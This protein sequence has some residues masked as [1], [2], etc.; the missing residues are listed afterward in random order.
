MI[1]ELRKQ[2]ILDRLARQEV[3][4]L[5]ELARQ[6]GISESTVRRDLKALEQEGQ[7]QLLRGGG[8]RLRRETAELR[9]ETK[10]GLNRVGKE[11]IARAAAALI[12]PG[13]V[14]FIDPSSTNHL[15]IDLVRAEG[16]M[17]ISNSVLHIT[18]LL[19]QGKPCMLIGGQI[20]AGTRSTYGPLA[21][22]GM[23]GLRFTKAFLGANG[24][25]EEAGITNHDP[26]ERTVKRLAIELASRSYFLIDRSKY[27]AVTLCKVAELTE[28]Q[29][30][31]DEVPPAL[32]GYANIHAAPPAESHGQKELD[33]M[34]RI[35]KGMAVRDETI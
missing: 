27:G 29:I 26:Q 17:F 12:E 35:Q 16:V 14:I 8:I 10:L 33:T 9:I 28:C 31:M 22:Q 34:P 13:D 19:E 23:G 24:L 18:K 15:L 3:L 30:L 2:G 21:E 20:K 4:L 6:M 5:T 32:A 11:A 1:P 7:I 25:S